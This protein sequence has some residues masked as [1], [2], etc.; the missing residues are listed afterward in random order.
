MKRTAI[1]IRTSTKKQRTDAQILSCSNYCREMGFDDI[2]TYIDIGIS[3]A[4]ASR[5]AFNR[6]IEDIKAGIIERVV[7][8]EESRIAR[9]YSLYMGFNGL[10]KDNS[11][12]IHTTYYHNDKTLGKD[13]LLFVRD[14]LGISMRVLKKNG[15]DIYKDGK[16][17]ID[18]DDKLH[19]IS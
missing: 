18:I 19:W 3:G 17:V 12:E 8:S 1:Y 5:P 2:N 11:I 13:E 7:C 6:L 4:K 10:C 15:Y 14:M 9:D 16:E